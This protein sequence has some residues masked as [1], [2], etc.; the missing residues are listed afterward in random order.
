MD[1]GATSG[2]VG[3]SGAAEAAGTVGM[4]GAAAWVIAVVAARVVV[5]TIVVRIEFVFMGRNQAFRIQSE[6]AKPAEKCHVFSDGQS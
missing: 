1:A 5:R 2:T 6:T 3:A 4:E